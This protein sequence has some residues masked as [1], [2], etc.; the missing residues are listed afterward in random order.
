MVFDPSFVNARPNTTYMWFYGMTNLSEIIGMEYLNT[1]EVENMISMF[2]GCS[3]LETIDISSFTT[4]KLKWITQ[5]FNQCTNLTTIYASEGWTLQ[6]AAGEQVIG[7][8]IFGA[9]EKLKGG[10]GTMYSGEHNDESYAHIDGGTANPGYFSEKPAFL[11]GDVN[12]DGT[13][14]VADV[15][16]LVSMILGNMPVNAAANVNGDTDVN[17]ADVTALVSIILGQ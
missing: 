16:M 1:S 10:A 3:S 2:E 15:T 11:K 6:N 13:V 17:V 7:S 12:G 8:L 4:G 9:D 14:N 5:M